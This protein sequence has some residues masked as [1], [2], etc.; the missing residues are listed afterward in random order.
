VSVSLGII[1]LDRWKP[2]KKLET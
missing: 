1:F 2:S